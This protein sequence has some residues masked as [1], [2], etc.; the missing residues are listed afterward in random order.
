MSKGDNDRT[1]DRARYEAAFDRIDWTEKVVERG[2][3][4]CKTI[5]C[6]HEAVEGG[7]CSYCASAIRGELE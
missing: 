7:R 5:G 3:V 4:Y 2:P 1:T 6:V